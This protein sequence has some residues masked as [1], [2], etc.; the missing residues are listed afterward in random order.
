MLLKSV[1]N[2]LINNELNNLSIGKPEWS[3]G[4]F[5]YQKLIQC[6][7]L[8]FIEL[9]KRFTLKK[10]LVVL[11]PVENENVYVLDIK[12]AV[13]NTTST[14]TKYIIDTA[15]MPFSNSIA[16]IDEVYDHLNVP[17]EF[18]TTKFGDDIYALNYRT[19]VIKEPDPQNPLTLVCRA[20]P[21]G[22][23][24]ANEGDLESY[25]LDIPNT[26]LEALI[27]YA[28]ARASNNRG[29]ENATNNEGAIFMARFEASCAQIS[30]VG[31]DTKEISVN[32]KLSQRGFV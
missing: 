23:T 3:T 27:L 31:L 24:L 16:K 17:I 5:S 6:I 11:Q 9:H 13:S 7:S 20:V 28:A 12:H 8:G 29:A 1:L 18:N 14:E 15:S 19:L 2:D 30:N 26:Y 22:I 32:D 10:E 21:G 4:N 25:E